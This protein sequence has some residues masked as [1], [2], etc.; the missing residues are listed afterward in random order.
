MALSK[1]YSACVS[2][3]LGLLIISQRWTNIALVELTTTKNCLVCNIMKPHWPILEKMSIW[4]AN[5]DVV[6]MI[7]LDLSYAT[8]GDVSIRAPNLTLNKQFSLA[9]LVML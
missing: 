5:K 4:R 9:R 8:Q 7:K 6:K 1:H 2:F 3:E